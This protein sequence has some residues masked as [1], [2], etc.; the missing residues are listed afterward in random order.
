MRCLL[1]NLDLVYY[2]MESNTSKVEVSK[3]IG[4]VSFQVTEP[5]NAKALM[6]LAHG[7]GA[8]M[9]HPFMVKLSEELALHQIA[10]IRYNFPYMERGSKRPDPAPIAEKTVISMLE[11]AKEE[12]PHL[13]LLAGG[14][15]FGGRMTSQL[16]SKHAV[17]SLKAIVFYG[18]PLHPVDNPGVERAQ[19]LF[20]V[21]VPMLFLQGTRDNLAQLPLIKTVCDKLPLAT[22]ALM[23]GADHSFK[24]SKKDSI[25]DLAKKS[26]DWLKGLEI[27]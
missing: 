2:S 21:L 24:K 11:M 4:W 23:E 16:L 8:G 6:V 3:S 15:S 27:L 12:F 20:D 5:P 13:S 14:K 9:N 26:G 7:A 17:P 19:H 25:V 1:N 22:L 10:S 18:F